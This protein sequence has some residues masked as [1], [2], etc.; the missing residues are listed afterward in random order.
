MQLDILGR[1][2]FVVNLH[3]CAPAASVEKTINTQVKLLLAAIDQLA[4]DSVVMSDRLR[5]RAGGFGATTADVVR[6]AGQAAGS[7]A[8]QIALDQGQEAGSAPAAASKAATV[9]LE[10]AG[11]VA[12][13]A[14]FQDLPP[15][16]NSSSSYEAAVRPGQQHTSSSS[17][18]PPPQPSQQALHTQQRQQQRSSSPEAAESQGHSSRRASRVAAELSS[19]QI[20][21][22]LPYAEVICFADVLEDDSSGDDGA[23]SSSG[24]RCVRSMD[25]AIFA[26][27]VST[28]Q[29]ALG[30][31]QAAAV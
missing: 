14:E 2:R 20:L 3:V 22:V 13:G 21:L 15:A 25:W 30:L 7:A 8:A 23:S 5:Q 28:A 10:A 19:M 18:G 17:S 9:L 24:H 4:A 27:C 11:V 31:Q 26:V 1:L 16:E 12:P 6:A 29:H